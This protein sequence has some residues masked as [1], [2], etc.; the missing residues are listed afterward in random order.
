MDIPDVQEGTNEAAA[1]ELNHVVSDEDQLAQG[2]G[3]IR[4]RLDK[5]EQLSTALEPVRRR[6]NQPGGSA[7]RCW[8]VRRRKL[9]DTHLCPVCAAVHTDGNARLADLANAGAGR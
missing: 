1:V 3:S 7:A 4:R 2:T 6:P 5:V 9:Q 8:L